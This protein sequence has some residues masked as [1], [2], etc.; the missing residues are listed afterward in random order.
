MTCPPIHLTG[1]SGGYMDHLR[2]TREIAGRF[3]SGAPPERRQCRPP[4]LS[5]APRMIDT[6]VNR[7]AGDLSLRRQ[8]VEAV[9]LLLEGGATVPFIA[10]YRKEATSS[11][12]E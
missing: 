10:R 11:L 6:H 12:D 1:T 3:P 4:V 8:Q 7:I 5:W 9:A 2:G